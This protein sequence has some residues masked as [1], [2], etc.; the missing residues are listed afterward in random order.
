[1]CFCFRLDALLRAVL[2]MAA[3]SFAALSSGHV[4]R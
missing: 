4:R 1:L 2:M 3:A